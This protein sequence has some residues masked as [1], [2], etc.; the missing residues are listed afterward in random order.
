MSKTKFE[1]IIFDFDGVIVDS[2]YL[3]KK[4]NIIALAH[5]EIDI[6][7]DELEYRF[8]GMDYP[9][10]LQNLRDEFGTV[11]TDK[12]HKVIQPTAHKLFEEELQALPHVIDYIKQTDHAYCI[13]SNSR[14]AIIK[15]K[16]EILGVYHL[17]EEKYFGADI[18]AKPKPATD[19]FMHSADKFG[20]AY[21]NCLVIEDG[22]HGIVAAS[23]LGM[24]SIGFTG[25]SHTIDNHEQ[26]LRDAGAV[27]IFDDMRHLSDIIASL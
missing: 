15:T 2:E 1:L 11:R 18:V 12:F 26:K 7:A 13:A 23:K 20:A 22:V 6:S 5:A 4:A 27:H 24:T 10:I 16:L 3:Y 17:F 14:Q 25:A 19:L 9:S 8:W 21:E